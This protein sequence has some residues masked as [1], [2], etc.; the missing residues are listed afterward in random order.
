M[1]QSDSAMRVPVLGSLGARGSELR[2][3]ILRECDPAR[4]TIQCHTDT[5]SPKVSE[6]QRCA[7]VQWVFYHPGNRIQLRASGMAGVHREG[8]WVDKIWQ[9]QHPRSRQIYLAEDAPGT[10]TENPTSGFSSTTLQPEPDF[11]STESGRINF[12]VI[13]CRIDLLDWLHLGVGANT[14]ARFEWIGEKV[15]ATWCVP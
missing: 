15:E 12:A 3:V 5:R 4:R 1:S 13:E 9:G 14:R 8:D 2:T 10:A 11:S 7:R 6:I